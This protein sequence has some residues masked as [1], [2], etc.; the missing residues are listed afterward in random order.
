M[1]EKCWTTACWQSCSACDYIIIEKES[2]INGQQKYRNKRLMESPRTLKLWDVAWFLHPSSKFELYRSKISSYG[3]VNEWLRCSVS[4][5]LEIPL[6]DRVWVK[7]EA[8]KVQFVQMY[9]GHPHF[10]IKA[11]PLAEIHQLQVRLKRGVIAEQ[12]GCFNSDV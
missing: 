8:S 12:L 11:V 7:R 1:V 2:N 4:H 10:C 6:W 5:L 3:F 9:A